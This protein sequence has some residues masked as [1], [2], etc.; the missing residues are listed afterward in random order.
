MSGP[1]QERAG[2]FGNLFIKLLSQLAS[3]AAQGTEHYN[4]RSKKRH[5]FREIR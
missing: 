3:L 2:L 1:V 5:V 4:I